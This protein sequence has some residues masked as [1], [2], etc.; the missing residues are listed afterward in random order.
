MLLPLLFVVVPLSSAFSAI[1]DGATKSRDFHGQ[2]TWV[3]TSNYSALFTTLLIYIIAT[4]SMT[5]IAKDLLTARRILLMP[6]LPAAVPILLAALYVLR[7]DYTAA[8]N[9]IVTVV[10]IVAVWISGIDKRD[11]HI[12]AAF[13]V[14]TGAA[15]VLF[16]FANPQRAIT[17]CRP[18]KCTVI[19]G[20][21]TSFFPQENVL[22]VFM[23]ISL[24]VV[25]F[26][27]E[28]V[29][30]LLGSILLIT[31]V[32]LSGS[33]TVTVAAVVIAILSL[34]MIH[35]KSDKGQAWLRTLSALIAGAL[36]VVSAVLFFVPL[37][38]LALT[39]RGFIYALLRDYWE[40]Q[41]LTGPGRSVLDHAFSTSNS[42][43]Y[44]I[45]HEH[46]GMPYIIVNGGILG[47]AF[48]SYWLLRLVMANVGHPET[49]KG[50]LCL[51]FTVTV[52]IVSL[53]EPVWTYDL[54]SPAFWTL[55]LASCTLSSRKAPMGL[56]SQ[57]ILLRERHL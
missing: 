9:V 5:I 48:F 18:D 2:W 55:A 40:Q 19:N 52:A 32:A 35:V 24:I 13:A 6:Y 54:R 41:P 33:R 37:D 20:L 10:V 44:A 39:G 53:T 27:F 14:G 30:R 43:N 26:G 31:L 29:P 56:P 23:I 16:A 17:P 15:T 47:L 45:S 11:I 38:S 3:T 25:M 49:W 46:G 57:L 36:F 7:S 21:L 12:L 8:L 50:A 51:V 1:I 4:I 22:A 42:A 34:A 28:G